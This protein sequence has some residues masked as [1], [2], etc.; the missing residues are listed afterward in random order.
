MSALLT[1]SATH[2]AWITKSQET[3]NLAYYHRGVALNGLQSAIGNFSRE[4]SDAILA[5]SILLSWQA[6]DWS[7]WTSLM[8][9]ISSVVS[10]MH[11]WKESS[12]FA[13][14]IED[15]MPTR[16]PKI[17]HSPLTS[18]SLAMMA[19]D[20]RSLNEAIAALQDLAMYLTPNHN[21]FTRVEMVLNFSRDL[22]ASSGSLRIEQLFE[23][24]QPLREWLFYE[25]ISL[26][27]GKEISS[28]DILILSHLYAVAL[29][30]DRS[31]PELGGAAFGN[32]TIGPIE[33]IDRK[34][35]YGQT[36]SRLKPNDSA[37]LDDMMRFPRQISAQHRFSRSGSSNPGGGSGGLDNLMP[38]QHSP[39]GVGGFQNLNLDSQ[40]STPGFPG[41][42]PLFSSHS[43]EDLS[44]SPSPFP[45]DFQNHP[46][47]VSS[48]R[49]SH[50]ATGS[51]VGGGT[52]P[53]PSYIADS[54]R[55]LS[56]LSFQGADSPASYSP[57]YSPGYFT[58]DDQSAAAAAA[59][60]SVGNAYEGL[61]STGGHGHSHSYS[62]HSHSGSGS[63]V[64]GGMTGGYGAVS[65]SFAAAG[66]GGFVAPHAVWT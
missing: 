24:L 41:T 1:F 6:S 38:G 35:R 27:Q 22:Q 18:L 47:S 50:L 17:G 32:L 45:T 51:S 37:R 60:D 21:L 14:Y 26:A 65:G 12:Q 63:I 15:H 31:I 23:K 7:G 43:S 54:A 42:Y 58:E 62:G 19:E 28:F 3:T 49:H 34:I 55:S 11:P 59:W 13:S 36:T 48:R 39:F 2:L 66:H 64:G 44:I 8:Q 52:S 30:V 61:S 33:E 46:S 4:N 9:G 53:R 10:S 29:A 25:P 20:D 40:P 56:G 57:S 16:S 5:A